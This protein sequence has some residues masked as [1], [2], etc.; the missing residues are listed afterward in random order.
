MRLILA[1]D[2]VTG[3]KTQRDIT[4]CMHRAGGWFAREGE[5]LVLRRMPACQDPVA[6]HEKS[7]RAIIEVAFLATAA[8]REWDDVFDYQARH[9][10]MLGAQTV[11]ASVPLIHRVCIGQLRLTKDEEIN[12]IT[13]ARLLRGPRSFVLGPLSHPDPSGTRWQATKW[14]LPTLRKTGISTSHSPF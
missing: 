9:H 14:L 12:G 10:Q 11:P 4:I 2:S 13:V 7:I 1:T 5:N 6:T 3:K 8:L